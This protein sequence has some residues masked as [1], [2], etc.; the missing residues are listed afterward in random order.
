MSTALLLAVG[1]RFVQVGRLHLTLPDGTRHS[2]GPG[3]GGPEVGITVSDP[4]A[5]TRI[6]LNADLALGEAYMDGSL[7]IAGD[8][9]RGFLKLLIRNSRL[10]S[11]GLLPGSLDRARRALRTRM[12]S[13]PLHRARSNVAHHYDLTAEFYDLFLDASKQ[14]TC[15]YFHEPDIG[16]EVAQAAK[17]ALIGRKLLIRPGMRVLDIGCGFGTLALSLARDF[18]AQVTGVTLSQVQLAEAEARAAAAGLSDRCTFRLQ[19]YRDV[20]GPFDRIVSVGMMEH[21]GLPHLATYFRRVRDLLTEDG[22]ALIHTIGRPGRPEA[23]SPWFDKYIFPGAYV[24]ALSEVT[25]VLERLRLTLCD[26]EIWRGHYERT[27]AAWYDRFSTN[28]DR[29]R[30]LYDDRFVRMW[31]Y[32]L[33]AAEQ[34]FAEDA[35]VIHQYQLAR[36]AR[37]VPMTRDYLYR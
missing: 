32:Y 37:A 15:A 26:L 24:P 35:L 27:L 10:P 30:A 20:E 34:S 33:I 7:T 29:A 13:N 14:Y 28:Q 11:P 2:F 31:R 5:V 21:V 25:P 17:M 16:L 6:I 22:V 9:L 4:A 12:G 18:G 3:R 8:D 1:R 19:D 23:I 36:H